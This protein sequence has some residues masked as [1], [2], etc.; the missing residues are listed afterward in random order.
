M[1]PSLPTEIRDFEK[2]VNDDNWGMSQKIDGE[3][4]LLEVSP[5]GI[6]GF[7]R[8]GGPK[9]VPKT[10]TEA[11]KPFQRSARLP[12][13]VTYIDGEWLDGKY[14]MFDFEALTQPIGK[15]KN[16][17]R[18]MQRLH[19]NLSSRDRHDVLQVVPLLLDGKIEALEE[20]RANNLE[21]V[22]FKKLD[23]FYEEGRT[24][25]F[26]KYKF[27]KEID[28]IVLARG[29]EKHNLTLGMHDG[30]DWTVNVSAL[31]AD[32]PTVTVGDV[33]TITIL[34]VSESG[35]LV[36][37]TSPRLRH[38]KLPEECLISQLDNYKVNKSIFGMKPFGET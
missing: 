36:Q 30:G 32:G 16:R 38:D 14:Y 18:A 37:P 12:S 29:E 20:M 17:L 27:T 5:Q 7:N 25:N 21:G 6:T 22:I 3:R 33:V 34:Y 31:T 35:K 4:L 10:L 2:Y 15:L 11:V 9:A 26:L 23:S 13:H 24:K 1:K 28:A 8:S 19:S